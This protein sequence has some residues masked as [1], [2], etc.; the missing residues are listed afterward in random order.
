MPERLD[1]G[2]LTSAERCDL[3]DLLGELELRGYAKRNHLSLASA[4]K[5]MRLRRQLER[6]RFSA[7]KAGV[8]LDALLK[9]LS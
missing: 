5:L 6:P 9:I 7:A 2:Q 1:L 8:E 4:T 3:T